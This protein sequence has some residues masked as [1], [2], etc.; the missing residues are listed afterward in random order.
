MTESMSESRPSLWSRASAIAARTPESRNRLVDF[1][2]A[3]S[4][5]AVISGHWLLA[6]PYVGGDGLTL[7]H[8]LRD[9]PWTQWLTWAF[10]VMPIFFLVGGYSNGVSWR[11]ALRDGRSYGDWL[12]ARL[13]RLIG[14]LLPLIVAWA[15]IGGVAGRLGVPAEMVRVGSQLALVPIWFLAVY[16]LVVVLV[17]LSHAFWRRAGFASFAVL[18]ALAV[19]NDVLFFAAG[20]RAVGWLNYAFVWLAVHQLGYAWLDGRL[21]GAL[22]RL[23]CGV[24]G[25]GLLIG[26]VTLG[27]HPLSMIS[28][29]GEGVSNTLPPKLPLLALGIAQSGVL[30]AF[31]G[32]LR[33]W[34]ARGVPW[35]ATVLL[36]GMIMTIYLWHLTAAALVMGLAIGLGGLGLGLAPGSAAWWLGRPAWLVAY[37]IA[38]AG[39]ALVLGR[40]ERGASELRPVAAWRQVAGALIICAGLAMLALNGVGGDGPLGLQLWALLLPFVGAALAGLLPIDTPWRPGETRAR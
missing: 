9:E 13:Q 12:T 16:T 15:V 22:P 25:L 2:R 38:L 19:G 3:A 26:L 27:P 40:F 32:P 39:L 37:L 8:L 7:A 24:A 5:L 23:A 31:E 14:P 10:Q 11:A 20:W 17:P 18:A 30:L 36:N 6:A 35:T 29:P 34:L 21:A 4:I 28:V 1:L 33:R